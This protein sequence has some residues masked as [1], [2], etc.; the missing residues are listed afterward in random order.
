MRNF[1][2]NIYYDIIDDWRD[3]YRLSPI[4]KSLAIVMLSASGICALS[5]YIAKLVG[6]IIFN[7]DWIVLI[8]ILG[9]FIMAG[10]KGRSNVSKTN[11]KSEATTENNIESA[12]MLE[13]N[14]NM[15]LQ[16]LYDV[17][18]P[19]HQVFKI[20]KPINPKELENEPHCIRK[21]NIVLYVFN[22]YKTG[23]MEIDFMQTALQSE[24]DM[25]LKRQ[26][27]IGVGQAL[28]YYQGQPYSLIQVE[29]VK[30]NQTH[31]QV[32]LAIANDNYCRYKQNR[33]TSNLL[34]SASCIQAPMDKDF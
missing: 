2:T 29:S 31:Y 1:I 8:C 28:F 12:Q 4:I 34:Q 22:L 10:L 27:F 16:A 24:I 3:G 15:L 33:L 7:I 23:N 20:K 14:Y 5:W 11:T 19:L 26:S 18:C 32:Y 21:G 25:N 13:T 30:D 17:V 9:A 6:Y